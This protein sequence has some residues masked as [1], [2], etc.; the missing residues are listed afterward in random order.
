MN[1]MTDSIDSLISKFKNTDLQEYPA[2]TSLNCP[3]DK[4]LWVLWVADA[5]F[6]YDRY[7][8]ADEISKILKA[9]RVAAKAIVVKRAFARADDKIDRE[10]MGEEPAYKIMQAGIDYLQE[11]YGTNE[12]E[13]YYIEGDKPRKSHQTLAELV[14]KAKGIMKILDPYYGLKTLDMLEKI[15]HGTGTRFITAKL[16]PN[17]SAA[18]FSREL[19]I[20]EKDH[21]SI[22]LSRYAKANE[23]HDRYILTDDTLIIL[24]HGLKDLGS[25]ESFVLVFKGDKGKDIRTALNQKFNDRWGKSSKLQ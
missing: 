22:E 20:F 10:Q 16:S 12:V 18:K 25:K 19:S 2:V 1:A 9:R 15:D 23:L 11:E 24:G 3:L 21:P 17:E 4:A 8:T 6:S 7:L 13:V 5:K 14:A